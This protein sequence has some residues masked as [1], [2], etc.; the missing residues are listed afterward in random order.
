MEF[1]VSH[2][3][4]CMKSLAVYWPGQVTV[5]NGVKRWIRWQSVTNMFDNLYC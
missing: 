5:R 4:G 1:L 2:I 3:P